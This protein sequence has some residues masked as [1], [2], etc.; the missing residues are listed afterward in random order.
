MY[1]GLTIFFAPIA[2]TTFLIKKRLIALIHT[3]IVHCGASGLNALYL[4]GYLT[5]R[6]PQHLWAVVVKILYFTGILCFVNPDLGDKIAHPPS[7]GKIT[8]KA[9]A[10]PKGGKE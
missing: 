8:Y 6:K 4:E 2:Y 1:Q 9:D 10:Y 7:E 3:K 5:E